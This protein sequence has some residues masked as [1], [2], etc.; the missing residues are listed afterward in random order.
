MPPLFV[1]P[2]LDNRGKRSPLQ[3]LQE[4]LMEV[5]H[6]SLKEQTGAGVGV[7]GRVF[8]VCISWQSS[9]SRPLY[10]RSAEVE[11]CLVVS[12]LY[13]HCCPQ[14]LLM[15]KD[16]RGVAVLCSTRACCA[17]TRP[18][19]SVGLLLQQSPHTPVSLSTPSAPQALHQV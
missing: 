10:Q 13:I 6:G 11:S 15:C 4:N 8:P 7:A 5:S 12:L 16:V 1:S 14:L 17:M 2:H 18:G 19:C 9:C 3:Q